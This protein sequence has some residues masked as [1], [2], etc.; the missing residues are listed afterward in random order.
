[1]GY[2]RGLRTAYLWPLISVRNFTRPVM[3][4]VVLYPATRYNGLHMTYPWRQRNDAGESHR[5]SLQTPFQAPE[6]STLVRRFNPGQCLPFS[7]R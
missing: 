3:P 5:N 7:Q 4:G 1:M 2:G 6:T